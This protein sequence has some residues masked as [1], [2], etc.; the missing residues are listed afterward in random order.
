MLFMPPILPAASWPM[1]SRWT[2]NI[3]PIHFDRE[4]A[5]RTEFKLG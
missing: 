2:Q 1:G 4:Y 5:A 3:N